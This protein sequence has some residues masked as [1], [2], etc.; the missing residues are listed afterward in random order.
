[1][2]AWTD[3][4]ITE[5][6]RLKLA[7]FSG[8]EIAQAIGGGRSRSAV[9]GKWSRLGLSKPG[10]NPALRIP[11]GPPKPK[12]QTLP[13][14]RNTASIP[15]PTLRQAEAPTDPVL[16]RESRADQCLYPLGDGEPDMLV[17]GA[18]RTRGSYCS[19]HARLAYIG[20]ETQANA[21]DKRFKVWIAGAQDKVWAA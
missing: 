21:R 5:L 14:P 11:K 3:Y 9:I 4:E 6:K 13:R 20:T 10:P 12:R 8:R 1:M 2:S 16:F 7:G 19:Q 18:P 17:C 15:M